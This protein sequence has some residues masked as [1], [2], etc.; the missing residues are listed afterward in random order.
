MVLNA[1][2]ISLWEIASIEPLFGADRSACVKLPTPLGPDI[3]VNFIVFIT[4]LYFIMI[5]RTPMTVL[6][7][8]NERKK[9]TAAA[10]SVNITAE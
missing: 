1:R 9:Q 7:R 5:S 10:A 2:A 3:Y 4:L 6:V 8:K